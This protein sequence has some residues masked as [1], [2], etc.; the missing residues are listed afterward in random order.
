MNPKTLTQNSKEAKVIST[1]KGARLICRIRKSKLIVGREERFRQRL[2]NY[3]IDDLGYDEENINV[4]E[5]MTHHKKGESGRADIVVF[6]KPHSEKGA[7]PLMVIECKDPDNVNHAIEE[8]S[9]EQQVLKYTSILNPTFQFI[10][11]DYFTLGKDLRN[12]NLIEDYIPSL[13][14]IIKNVTNQ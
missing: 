6:D 8:Y 7:K 11:N 2:L 14:Q 13:E 4:E 9:I 3:L 12:E 5:P 10:T 1:D